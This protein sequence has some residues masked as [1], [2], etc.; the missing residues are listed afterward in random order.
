LY[1]DVTTDAVWR[2]YVRSAGLINHTSMVMTPD[3]AVSL[4]FI[5]IGIAGEWRIGHKDIHITESLCAAV[6][7]TEYVDV[8][9]GVFFQ[10]IQLPP[11]MSGPE[12]GV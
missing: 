4:N 1:P 3:R 6:S 7:P 11:C 5:R 12:T 8:L 9:D 10:Q 2:Y